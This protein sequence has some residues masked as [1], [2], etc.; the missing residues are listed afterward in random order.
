MGFSFWWFLLFRST[1]SVAVAQGCSGFTVCGSS[2]IRDQTC[3]FCVG[4]Q[5]LYRWSTREARVL[6]VKCSCV[7][8]WAVLSHVLLTVISLHLFLLFSL[9]CVLAFSLSLSFILYRVL[10][11]LVFLQNNWH[12]TYL[13][14]PPN[15][16]LKTLLLSQQL[17]S[18]RT[19]INWTHDFYDQTLL[20]LRTCELVDIESSELFLE[21]HS[22]LVT[23]VTSRFKWQKEVMVFVKC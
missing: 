21:Y 20:L 8:T 3:V 23:S 1:G 18:Q 2:W 5:I 15:L 17:R 10:K 9:L 14:H 7:F 13:P 12:I 22:R 11:D 19:E 16:A 6:V 4:R